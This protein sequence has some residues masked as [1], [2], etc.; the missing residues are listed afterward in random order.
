[1][2]QQQLRLESTRLEYTPPHLEPQPDYRMVTGLSTVIDSFMSEDF[3][4]EEQ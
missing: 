1:M 4:A 3:D 2:P